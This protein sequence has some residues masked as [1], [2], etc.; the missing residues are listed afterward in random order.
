MYNTR[1]GLGGFADRVGALA[2]AL[3]PLTV[4]LATRESILSLATGIPY[5]S[6][7]FL[8]RWLGRI[9][10]IQSFLHTLSWTLIEGHFYLPQP[11]TFQDF[12]KEPYIIW[13]CVAMMLI[14]FLYIFSLTSIIKLTGYEFFKKTHYIVAIVYIGACWGHWSKLACWMIAALGVWGIDRAVRLIRVALIHFGY[15]DGSKGRHEA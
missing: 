2:Y 4:A 12:I 9:I 14:T 8:H 6:F 10:F 3:T 11:T 15:L 7:N 13:G 5:Q 1:T